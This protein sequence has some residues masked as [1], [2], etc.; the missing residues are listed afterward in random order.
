MAQILYGAPVAAAI[1]EKTSARAAALRARGVV[2]CLAMLRLGEDGGSISYE[3]AAAKRCAALGID[4][5]CFAL[6]ES[7]TQAELLALIDQINQDKAIHGCLLMLPLP[8]HL[9]EYAVCHALRAEK[10]VDSVTPASMSYVFS[11]LGRGFA[12]CTA[13]ACLK[14]LDHYHVELA[15]AR[16]AVIGRSL[17]VGRP[18]SMLLQGRNATVTVCHTGTRDLAAVC[19]EQDIVISAAGRA[20]LIGPEALRAGQTVLDVGT[21]VGADG[22]LRG[23]LRFEEAEP[24]VRAITPVPGGVG[25]VTSAVLAEHVVLAA[26]RQLDIVG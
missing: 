24:V 25:A 12:A 21:S 26:E 5:R 9:D 15:G 11:G 3:R 22:K 2:P 20:G 16:V 18:L 13:E 6:P 23:D 17:S 19:R 7:S 8:A 10:D 1:N 4:T 14:V